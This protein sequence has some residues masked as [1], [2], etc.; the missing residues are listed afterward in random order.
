MKNSPEFAPHVNSVIESITKDLRRLSDTFDRPSFETL[1]TQVL[2]VLN[3]AARRVFEWTLQERS[4]EYPEYVRVEGVV[5]RRHLEGDVQYHD[6]CGPLRV[7]RA[8]YRRSDKRNGETI[9][10]LDLDAGL[11]L[12]TTP[13]LAFA[14]MQGHANSP[15]RSNSRRRLSPP[16]PRVSQTPS[17]RIYANS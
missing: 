12:R 16:D 8:T 11:I 7:R 4:D 13:V 15:P 14:V 3:E 10:P 1:Q 5:Y 2:A 9:V 17:L 6:L